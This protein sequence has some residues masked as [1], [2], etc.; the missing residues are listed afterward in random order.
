VPGLGVRCVSTN[1]WVTGAESSE[2]VMALDALG[3][4]EGARQVLADIRHLRAE[5]GSY[6][7]GYVFPD[8]V[9]W[10]EERTTYTA[11]A[12]LLAVDALTHLTAGS[13]I[14]RGSSLAADFAPIA[15]GCGCPDSAHDVARVS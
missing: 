4:R 12:V 1:P 7:T 11:A 8:D 2:L 10:P 5:D 9:N 15:L 13:D 6:W 14:V 3:D